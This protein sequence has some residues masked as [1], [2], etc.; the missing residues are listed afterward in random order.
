MET[1]GLAKSSVVAACSVLRLALEEN[2]PAQ[3]CS[4][5]DSSRCTWLVAL[6]AQN[7]KVSRRPVSSKL[8][9]VRGRGDEEA[10]QPAHG[11]PEGN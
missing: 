10:A 9:L 1:Q 5:A 2:L 11:I 7:T 8:G 3:K 4:A 6:P